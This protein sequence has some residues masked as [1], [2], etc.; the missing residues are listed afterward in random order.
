MAVMKVES[1]IIASIIVSTE[2]GSVIL[3]IMF[4]KTTS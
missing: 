1:N 2:G 4:V 3:V